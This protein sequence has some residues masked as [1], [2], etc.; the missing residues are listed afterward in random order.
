M[1]NTNRRRHKIGKY[2]KRNT[3][4]TYGRA[5]AS[6]IAQRPHGLLAHVIAGRT[7]KTHKK[8]DATGVNDLPGV[9]GRA[10]RNVGQGPVMK[11][12]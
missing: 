3:K 2:I 7:E 9:D 10:R 11:K 5:V 6:D 8:G 12:T 1:K 4:V